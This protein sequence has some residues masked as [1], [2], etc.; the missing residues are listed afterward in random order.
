MR[1]TTCSPNNSLSAPS[2]KKLYDFRPSFTVLSAPG[3]KT[4]P[5]IDGTRSEV[6][7]ALDF[8]RRVVLIAGTAY[9]GEIK[10]VHL[11]RDELSVASA[12]RVSDAL[13]GEHGGGGRCRTVFGLSGTGKTSLSA[14]PERRLIGDDEHGWS[15][16]G[17]FNFEGGMLR[18]VY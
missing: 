3:F 15:D 7:V 1:G 13:L 5:A 2:L 10:E 11:Y 8:R 9:A 12:G 17:V 6:V 18:E 16:T 14:D 4:D